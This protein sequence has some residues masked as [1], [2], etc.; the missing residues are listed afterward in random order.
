M[1][2]IHKQAPIQ[3]YSD[4]VKK[5]KPKNWDDF[6]S[7]G[8]EVFEETRS[9]I[10]TVEQFRLCGYTERPINNEKKSHIDH[11]RKRALF[12]KLTFDWNNFI[13]ATIDEDFGAKY[14]DNKYKITKE[15]YDQIFNPVVDNV[16]D[17]FEYTTWGEIK[18]KEILSDS[19]K[20]KA[21]KTIEVFNLKHVSL[22]IERRNLIK[23]I[24]CYSDLS[25]EEK[26]QSLKNNGFLSLLEQ[27]C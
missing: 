9:T 18:S 10:L 23:I 26:I 3:N 11:Y 14:K 24:S 27:Y 20:A 4:F 25:K 5:Q 13:V 15:E 16:Q 17:Y 2:K 1:R 21:L 19:L 8:Q 12:P 22:T 7:L 6:H